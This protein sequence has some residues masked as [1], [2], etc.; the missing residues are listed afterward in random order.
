MTKTNYLLSNRRILK[1]CDI[2]RLVALAKDHH[3]LTVVDNT[4]MT[5]LYQDP[6]AMEVD[7]VVESV[8]K[9][10]NGHSDVVAGLVETND[11]AI[12]N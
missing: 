9:F 5:A 11:E 12:Y 3:V 8:T 1:V 7:I 4:F 10:I 6:L 2:K